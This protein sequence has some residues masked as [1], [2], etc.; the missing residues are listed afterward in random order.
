MKRFF[1]D[2]VNMNSTQ[3][4][5]ENETDPKKEYPG[6]V[7][8]WLQTDDRIKF[9][10]LIALKSQSASAATSYQPRSMYHGIGT[11]IVCYIYSVAVLKAR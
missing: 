8:M 4:I 6:N 2:D 9:L 10:Y 3:W 5:A 11:G 7:Q 1:S